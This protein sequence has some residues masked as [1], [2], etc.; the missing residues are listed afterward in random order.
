MEWKKIKKTIGTEKY[1]T[2]SG[3]LSP[4]EKSKYPFTCHVGKYYCMV[5]KSNT[6]KSNENRLKIKIQSLILNNNYHFQTVSLDF[7]LFFYL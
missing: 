1:K 6:F 4:Y 3:S 5:L 7:L 2:L